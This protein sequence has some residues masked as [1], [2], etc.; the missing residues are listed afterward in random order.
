MKTGEVEPYYCEG[1][2]HLSGLFESGVL[3]FDERLHID[4]S[5][6]RYEAFK[7]WYL[8]T[9]KALLA[10]YLAKK[11]AKLF[12]ERFAVKEEGVYLPTSLHVKEFVVYYWALHQAMGREI[13]E[14]VRREAWVCKP[15]L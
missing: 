10:H 6:A 9:Y 7:A 4:M 3:R 15:S 13:D 1:L 2:I 5:E 8:Q 12:L 11:D 14:S